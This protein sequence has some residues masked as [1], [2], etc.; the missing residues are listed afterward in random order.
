MPIEG[1]GPIGR[2]P[3]APGPIKKLIDKLKGVIKRGE[4]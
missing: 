2:K 1:S 4:K 3:P